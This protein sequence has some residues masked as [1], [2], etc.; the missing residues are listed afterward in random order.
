MNR[1]RNLNVVHG[2]KVFPLTVILVL[3]SLTVFLSLKVYALEH[4]QSE[5]KEQLK[6]ARQ[7]I[8]EAQN[9]LEEKAKRTKQTCDDEELMIQINNGEARHSLQSELWNVEDDLRRCKAKHKAVSKVVTVKA[10][11][12]SDQRN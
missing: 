4:A 8:E 9:E 10:R 3:L 5:L 1:L 7:T 6:G 11:V 2:P 12:L